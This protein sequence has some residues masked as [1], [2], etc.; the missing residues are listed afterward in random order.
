MD[1]KPSSQVNAVTHRPAKKN[2]YKPS[3]PTSA[4]RQAY[5]HS[6]KKKVDEEDWKKY[7]HLPKLSTAIKYVSN[8]KVWKTQPS[9]ADFRMDSGGY[10]AR[11]FNSQNTSEFLSLEDAQ[12]TGFVVVKSESL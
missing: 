5:K 10:T 11:K 8:S 12:R 3:A 6:K 1:M 2:P 7:G 4:V 9:I